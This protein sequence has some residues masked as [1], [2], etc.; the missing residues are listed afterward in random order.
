[1]TAVLSYFFPNTYGKDP[2]NC[3]Y[4][5][6]SIE[7]KIDVCEKYHLLQILDRKYNFI[8]DG[9][10]YLLFEFELF[11]KLI[12]TLP[13]HNIS[14]YDYYRY[15]EEFNRIPE[16]V[17][18]EERYN[19]T[20]RFI[21]DIFILNLNLDIGY[22]ITMFWHIHTKIFLRVLITFLNNITHVRR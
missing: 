17:K 11:R 6:E 1:M 9:D 3:K 18:S 8:R 22:F 16:E 4:F 12:T 19:I 21:C 15:I 7:D 10:I 13:K 5:L 2:H 20:V 14:D